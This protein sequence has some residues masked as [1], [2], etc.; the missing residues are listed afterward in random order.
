MLHFVTTG[1]C[2]L[3]GLYFLPSISCWA[4]ALPI[5]LA[6]LI[7]ENQATCQN[8]QVSHSSLLLKERKERRERC[9]FLASATQT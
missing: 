7:C 4:S 3:K 6:L 8:A 5:L 9:C 2:H 1:V